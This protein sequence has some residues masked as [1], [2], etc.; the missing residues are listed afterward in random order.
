MT[1]ARAN[2]Q[3]TD[4]VDAALARSAEQWTPKGPTA[5]PFHALGWVTRPM[6]TDNDD[7]SSS[8]VW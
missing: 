8:F 4:M 3:V 1:V 7:V 6:T 5:L 2:S